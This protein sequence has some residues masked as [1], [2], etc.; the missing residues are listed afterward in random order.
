MSV[1]HDPDLCHEDLAIFESFI[2]EV[3][4]SMEY[5]HT[6]QARDTKLKAAAM[7]RNI[8]VR[9]F[10]DER[11]CLAQRSAGLEIQMNAIMH[12]H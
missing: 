10:P 2:T 1:G 8:Y 4:E 3:V 5:I 6:K 7:M 11:V 12:D 9:R